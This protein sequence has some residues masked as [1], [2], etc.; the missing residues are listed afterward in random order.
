MK[1]VFLLALVFHL[2]LSQAQYMLY[3]TT[4]GGDTYDAGTI[5]S[6]NPITNKQTTVFVFNGSDG[7]SPGSRL[8]YASDS[9][10]YGTTA[11]GG[12]NSM[13]TVFSFNWKT[14]QENVII[15]YDGINGEFN[16]GGNELIQA[17][18]GLL[19]GTSWA[20]GT[21][22]AGVLYRYD[23]STGKDTVLYNFD[24]LTSGYG[25]MLALCEDTAT[26]ILYGVTEAGG[27]YNG[28]VI[29][30]FNTVTNQD[31]IYY[32]FHGYSLAPFSPA[33]GFI[34]ASNGLFYGMTQGGGDSDVGTIYTFNAVNGIVDTVFQFN[35]I[36]GAYPDGNGLFQASNGLIYGT[37]F[38]GGTKN[39]GVLFSFNPVNKTEKVLVNF[40]DTDGILPQFYLVQDPDNGILYGATA[41][42]GDSD[43]GILYSYDT[44]TSTY[45]KLLDFNGD[46]G[47]VPISLTLVKDT[48]VKSVSINS[49]NISC[50]GANNGGAIASFLGGSSPYTYS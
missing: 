44:T 31:S 16:T 19:Y 15:N 41:Y 17:T 46:N 23:I 18:N 6:Y 2:S 7:Y 30:G 24:T 11:E 1:K 29:H 13:G 21:H 49:A 43:K 5:F 28:G 12:T 25:P 50:N 47:A 48:S 10:L 32:S 26:G 40:N 4:G 42:G 9:L 37:T 34:R 36:D 27:V 20:G 33:C 14:N 35:N 3:G 38:N 39:S 8:L 22:D 45:K